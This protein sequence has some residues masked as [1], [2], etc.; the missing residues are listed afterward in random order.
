[1]EDAPYGLIELVLVF[2]ALL[3]LAVWETVRTRRELA[4][5]KR[6]SGRS[7]SS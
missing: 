4:Q 1:M 2:G 6:E 5:V 7:A 3:G